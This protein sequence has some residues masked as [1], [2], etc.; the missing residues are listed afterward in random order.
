[1]KHEEEIKRLVRIL[2]HRKWVVDSKEAEL[3][4]YDAEYNSLR[5]N[6]SIG[7][8]MRRREILKIGPDDSDYDRLYSAYHNLRKQLSKHDYYL[9]CKENEL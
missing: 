3:S 1:M 4:K 8:I 9:V 6:D 2:Q 5:G 7:A